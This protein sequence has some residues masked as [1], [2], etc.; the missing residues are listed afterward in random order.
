MKGNAMKFRAIA[1]GVL[2][3]IALMCT[4]SAAE[5]CTAIADAATGQ[6]LVQRGDCQ[7]A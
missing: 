5:V 1:M 4:A 2:G 6:V 7:R 3:S